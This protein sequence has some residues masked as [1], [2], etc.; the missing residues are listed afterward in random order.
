MGSCYP[1][2]KAGWS[3]FTQWRSL[4]SVHKINRKYT[5]FFYYHNITSHI[6]PD[7]RA[8]TFAN[9]R[10]SYTRY[11][12][13]NRVSY[14]TSYENGFGTLPFIEFLTR[15]ITQSR[16]NDLL[17]TTSRECKTSCMVWRIAWVD[18]HSTGLT[19][20][21]G[22]VSDTDVSCSCDLLTASNW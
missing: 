11:L 9:W 18:P 14:L 8:P 13:T 12:C 19:R 5:A 21:L 16:W 6:N 7:V 17:E 15:T 20:K 2:P 10:F 3:F 4:S 1:R 22:L